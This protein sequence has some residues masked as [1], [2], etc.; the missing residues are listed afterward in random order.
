M[1]DTILMY[2]LSKKSSE[3]CA[4]LFKS[5]EFKPENGVFGNAKIEITS[6]IYPDVGIVFTH[7]DKK[8]GDFLFETYLHKSG[9]DKES[10]F[11]FYC[12]PNLSDEDAY[13]LRTKL[14]WILSHD[15]DN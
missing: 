1:K 7:K 15:G 13:E 14:A 2:M 9:K 5:P 3:A 12:G 10:E 8:S 4:E 6:K 11:P